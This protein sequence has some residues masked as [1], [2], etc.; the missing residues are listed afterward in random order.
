MSPDVEQP[1]SADVRPLQELD[2]PAVAVG[3]HRPVHDSAADAARRRLHIDHHLL[4]DSP[5]DR[6]RW[7]A[8]IRQNPYQLRVYRVGVAIVGAFLI[9]LVFV[10]G[11]LP[12]PGGIPLVL[13]GLAIWSSEFKWAH[14]LMLLFKVQLRRF[15][16]WSRRRQVLFWA[17]F[18]A[19]C[20]LLG[21]TFM[22]LTGIPGWVPPPVEV[23]L[24]R[25]PGL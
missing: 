3:P 23:L 21:F 9:V 5:E 7:R 8:K 20:G 24:Q 25:L 14:R 2:P 12:G 10:S 11:P 18:V 19:C 1:V 6:W 4:R 16:T 15:Q 17:A 13:L 22:L